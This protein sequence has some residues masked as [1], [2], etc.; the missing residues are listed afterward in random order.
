MNDK[1]IK[2]KGWGTIEGT[3]TEFWDARPVLTGSEITLKDRL[4]LIFFPKKFLL[5]KWIRKKIK[6]GKKIRILDVGCGTGAA[7]IEMK[8]LWGKQVEVV[9]IDVI[10]MQIDLA[11]ERVKEY[12]VWAKFFHY[13]G[14]KLPFENESFD[15]I[16]TSDVLGHVRD[17]PMWLADLNRVLKPGGIITMF[18][19]SKLGRHAWIRNYLLKRGLNTDPHVE[20]HI[21]LFGKH[22]LHALLFDAGFHVKKMYSTFWIKFLAHPDELYDALQSQKKFSILKFLNKIFFF[23]K[24]K[25]H[26]FSTAF[27]ELYGLIEMVTIGRWIESQGYVILGVKSSKVDK[28]KK[29]F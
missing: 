24:K 4:K 9:G 7:V 18:S 25:T 8:K 20:F 26:P 14:D 3:Q 10:Q 17:V 23:V 2:T 28:V 21:S 16:Y 5:Y 15:V 12:G 6:N 11:K 27:W 29:V 22:E 1:K 19:E 13:D